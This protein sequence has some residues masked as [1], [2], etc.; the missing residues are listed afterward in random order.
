MNF[1]PVVPLGGLPGWVFLNAT[2]GAQRQAFDADPALSRDTDHFEREIGKV[3]TAEAL[4]SD[5]RLLRVALGAFGLQDDI[6]SRFFIR[7]VLEGGTASPDTLANRLTDD[8]YRQLADAFGFGAA[9]GPRTAIPGFGT[10]ITDAYRSRRFEIAVGESDAALRLA[11][12]ARRELPR[13]AAAPVAEDTRWL[14]IMGTPP[15]REVFETALGL[16]DGF[17]RLELDRQVAVFRERSSAQLGLDS[18][19]S[20][21]DEA[22]LDRVVRRYVLREQADSFVSR[23]SPASVALTLLQGARGA[24]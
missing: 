21:T 9:G 12:N 23:A 4:V 5:R 7:K 6:D 1:S 17:G 14:R 24:G 8:R 22:V 13:I 16:P 18:L 11:M 15:L 19:S 10:A 20:L 3:Q 2:L